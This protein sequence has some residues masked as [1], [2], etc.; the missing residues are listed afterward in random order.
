MNIERASAKERDIAYEVHRK[1]GEVQIDDGAPV[2][3]QD[4]GVWVQAW[5]FVSNETLAIS[6]FGEL[7]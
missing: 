1:F 4:D 5:I 2:K 7:N 6:N 3:R